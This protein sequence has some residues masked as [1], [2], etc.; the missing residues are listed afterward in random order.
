MALFDSLIT[1]AAEKFG[2]GGKATS[3]VSALLS[4]ISSEPGGG[5]SGFLDRFKR[6][7]LSDMVASWVGGSENVPLTTTQIQG[8]LGR[9]WLNTLSAKVGLPLSSITP[10]LTFL[11]PTVVNKL[12]PNGVIPSSLPSLG[13]LI[14]GF[15][16]AG[17]GLEASAGRAISSAAQAAKPHGARWLS[18]LALLALALIALLGYLYFSR[19]PE[20]GPQIATTAS[21]PPSVN[22]QLNLSNLDGKI[23]FSSVVPNVEA[24][25]AILDQLK[26]NFG[27]GNFIGNITVDANAK[28]AS[29]LAKLGPAL[30]AFKIPGAEL[31]FDGDAISVGG[32]GVKAG[33]LDQLKPIFGDKFSFKSL[34][35]DVERAV[36]DAAAKASAALAALRPDS[37]A[38][39]LVGALNQQIIN[40]AS[41]KA[42]I[43]P[44][45]QGLLKES[46]AAIKART[47]GVRLEVGGHTDSQGNAASNQRLSQARAEAVR[48]FLMRNGVKP[49]TLIAK[50]YGDAKPIA[51]ND[52]EAGRFKNRRIEFSVV[53]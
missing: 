3:L 14:S 12:T 40:F 8:A 33:L 24:R 7:G 31:N 51:S 13:S 4:M 29:W 28:P 32:E 20:Q 30:A 22:A 25:Q 52:T 44:E 16:G 10:A 37:S 35:L 17:S 26:A 19:P 2:L 48:A 39:E 21:A 11:I 27:E 6:A 5:L 50:G 46:A 9:D 43:Q 34:T 47:Q 15:A 41:G 42:D 36:K 45:Y 53:K 38:E 49:E 1:E 23:K 18:L